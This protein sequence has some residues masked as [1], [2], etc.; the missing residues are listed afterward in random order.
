MSERK[1]AKAFGITTPTGEPNGSLVKMLIDG[2][3]PSREDTL[4]RC[5]LL[6]TTK[7]P[8]IRD[9]PARRVLVGAWKLQGHWVSPED[10]FGARS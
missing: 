8:I 9:E 2:Y 5:G 3:I 1:V 10:Y 6:P 4:R 7:P